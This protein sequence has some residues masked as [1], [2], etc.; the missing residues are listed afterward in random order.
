MAVIA[1]SAQLLSDAGRLGVDCGAITAGTADDGE[2]TAVEVGAGILAFEAVAA[3]LVDV[4]CGCGTL[5]LRNPKGCESAY[6]CTSVVRVK[7]NATSPVEPW[8]WSR[9]VS[10]YDMLR[11]AMR[12]A[13][14]WT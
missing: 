1:K 6:I 9:K 2:G 13:T 10:A 8:R 14:N 7:V 11:E 12:K 3:V 4:A 5:R